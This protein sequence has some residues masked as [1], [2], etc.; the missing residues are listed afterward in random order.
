MRTAHKT[1]YRRVSGWKLFYIRVCWEDICGTGKQQ[2]SEQRTK[3]F[4]DE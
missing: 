4:T 2:I 1:I 3:R